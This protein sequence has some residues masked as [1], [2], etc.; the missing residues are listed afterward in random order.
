VPTCRSGAAGESGLPV[1]CR[2]RGARRS[3]GSPV[4][5]VSQANT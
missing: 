5:T 3:S 4:L 1:A 2:Q